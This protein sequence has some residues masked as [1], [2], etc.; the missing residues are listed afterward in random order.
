[1]DIVGVIRWIDQEPT[2]DLIKAFTEAIKP[3]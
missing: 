2:A 1:L 3:L